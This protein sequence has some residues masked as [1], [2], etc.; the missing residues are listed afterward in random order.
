MQ[1]GKLKF[2]DSMGFLQMPLSGFTAA[3]GLEELKKGFFP[4]FFNT[5]D[6]KTYVGP[7]PAEEYYDPDGMKPER[8]QEF[9]EWYQSKIDEKYEF[10]FQQ[11][12]QDYCQSDVLA[13][14]RVYAIPKEFHALADFNPME[15]CITIASACNRYF[16]KK[17]LQP[18]TIAQP[19]R[20]WHANPN[21][22]PMP[23]WN[24]C[25]G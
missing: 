2:I 13:E 9:D 5:Q 17:C 12:L 23:R 25:I 11:E 20:G 1:V 19:I 21:L 6:H 16:R 15:H 22:I 24:G 3:F 4:H 18:I 7:M 10:D 8:K 14:R